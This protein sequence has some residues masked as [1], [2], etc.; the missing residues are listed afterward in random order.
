MA[1]RRRA[2]ERR[3]RWW[4]LLAFATLLALGIIWA[5]EPVR[6]AAAARTPR[7]PLPAVQALVHVAAASGAE[8]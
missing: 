7:A 1:A 6:P 4:N 3:Q 8:H 2:E 5:P